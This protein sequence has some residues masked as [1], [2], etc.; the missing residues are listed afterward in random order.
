MLSEF[1]MIIS[2]ILLEGISKGNRPRGR[3]EKKWL[4]DIGHF[5]EEEN[6][7]LVAPAGHVARNRDL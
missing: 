2:K 4:E 5:Y 7:R 6:I 3:P 1:T